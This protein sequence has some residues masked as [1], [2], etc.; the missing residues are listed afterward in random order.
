[1]YVCTLVLTCVLN[2]NAGAESRGFLHLGAH[3][4]RQTPRATGSKQRGKGSRGFKGTPVVLLTLRPLELKGIEHWCWVQ[5]DRLGLPLLG[6]PHV[7]NTRR[8]EM[9]YTAMPSSQ[10]I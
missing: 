3:E 1:M 9:F 4:W 5:S 8:Q 2:Q 6:T 10:I 7:L